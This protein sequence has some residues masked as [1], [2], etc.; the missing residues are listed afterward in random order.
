[1]NGDRHFKKSLRVMEMNGKQDEVRGLLMKYMVSE[2]YLQS[3]TTV[4]M[5]SS[6]KNGTENN[7]NLKI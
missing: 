7:T 1:M 4:H 3:R 6:G 5:A 2:Q